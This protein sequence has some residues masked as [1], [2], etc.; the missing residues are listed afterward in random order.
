MGQQID[1]EMDMTRDMD[2]V[3]GSIGIAWWFT[4]MKDFPREFFK[5]YVKGKHFLD[6]GCGDGRMIT[7]AMM[8][9]AR[10]YHGVEIDGELIQKASMQRY[11]KKCDFR[12]INLSLYNCVYY[13]L[14]ST[15]Q[16]PP[17]SKGELEFIEYIKNLEGILIIYYRKVSH[18]LQKLHDNLISEGFV[19]IDNEVDLRVYRREK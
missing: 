11:I 4:R 18:R 7:L 9:G 14:G 13:F 6:I 5:K 15:E 16:V 17:E 12:E 1:P 3:K 19:E 10:K 8:C 2:F